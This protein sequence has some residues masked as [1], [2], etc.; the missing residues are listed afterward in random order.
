MFT[1]FHGQQTHSKNRT[2]ESKSLFEFLGLPACRKALRA[3][4]QLYWTVTF[5]T[6]EIIVE[7]DVPVTVIAAGPAGVPG[8]AGVFEL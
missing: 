1:S 3:R 5:T 6:V 7:P 2:V 8:V 4:T